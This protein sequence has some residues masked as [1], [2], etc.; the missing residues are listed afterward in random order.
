VCV[1][2]SL[3]LGLERCAGESIQEIMDILE[4][5][6]DDAEIQLLLNGN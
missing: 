1:R 4:D 5:G 2:D 3:L 6:D